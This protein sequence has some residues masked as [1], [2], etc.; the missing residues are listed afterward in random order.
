MDD[1]Q[2]QLDPEQRASE[3]STPAPDDLEPNGSGRRFDVVGIGNAIVDVLA[4]ADDGF[5]T[6]H[7]LTKGSMRLVEADESDRLY[8]DMPRA[9]EVSGGSAANTIAG[10]ASLGGRAAYIGKVRDDQLGQVFVHDI[11]AEGVSFDVPPAPS[12]PSTARCLILVTPDAERTMNTYLGASVHLEPEDVDEA[13][14][15]GGE[16]LYLEG[17]LWDRPAAQDAFRLAIAAARRAGRRV[18][19][20]LS[21]LFCVERHREGFLGLLDEGAIDVLFAN[22]DELRSLF[23]DT[24]DRSI[25]Q[26]RS[27]CGFVAVTLGANGSLLLVGDE[28]FVVEAEPVDH[29]VDT[30]GAG[31]LYAAGVLYGLASGLD[32]V[33]CGRL[34]S[35]AAGEVIG[36]VGAR[37]EKPL[38]ELAVAA[39]LL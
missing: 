21:D 3:P 29:V 30:T 19:L 11:R 7:G 18:S 32:P 15:A 25:E 34:A 38:A 33:T 12:G 6:G 39:G 26:V 17:Y 24:L 1:P 20:T 37:P 5:I 9:V 4:H 2:Q 16:L 31:D 28:T 8:A 14:V 27:R 35:M 13:V 22:E 10:V 36:H 23:Q